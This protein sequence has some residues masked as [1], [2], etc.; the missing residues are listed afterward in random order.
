[1]CG[2]VVVSSHGGQA[3]PVHL[4]LAAIH[5]RGPD[6][7]GI[8][9]SP[10]RDCQLGHAR[11]SI[12]DLSPTGH[13]PMSDGSGRYMLCYNGETYNFPDLR[14]DLER[15][16]G[17]VTWRGSSDSEVIIEGFAREGIP[18]LDRLN[19]MF[20]L[21]IYDTQERL[22]HILRDPIGIKPLFIT[23]QQGG[24]YFC[25]EMK[26]LLALPGL[27]FD[28]RTAALAEQLSFM[29]VPEPYT[30]FEQIRK[31]EPGVC[32]SYRDG[33]LVASQPLFAHLA[34]A[35]RMH[36]EDE[37][38]QALRAAFDVAVRRQ[39]M[40]DVP[41]SVFLSGGLDSSAVALRAVQ[42]GA[43]VKDAYTIAFHQDDQRHD[44]QSDDLHH[45]RIMAERLGLELKVITAERNFLGLLP[46]LVRF[47]ED[48]FSDPAAINTYLISAGARRDGIKVL[49]SGQGADEYL[50]GYRRYLAEK[51]LAALPRPLRA[52]LGRMQG[53]LPATL[54]GRFNALN[55]RMRRL[56]Q[57]AA[58]TPQARLKAMYTWSPDATVRGLMHDDPGTAAD[59]AFNTYVA[60]HSHAD[61]L[62]TMMA[63]DRQYDLL[64]LN[65]CYTDRMSMAAS[66]EARVPF[67]DFDLVRTMNAIPMAM[68]VQG[69]QGKRVFKRAMTPALPQEI[70]NRAKA[71]FGLPIRAWL[72]QGSAL[73]DHYL[74]QARLQRQGLY[75]AAAVRQLLDAQFSG[76]ADHSHTLLT[77]L[78]QQLW[79]EQAQ[80]G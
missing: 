77:L 18:F 47:M 72:R 68:K 13:Q 60:Q 57:L 54:P 67:L 32:R 26:G 28:L 50:G 64:S 6:D 34:P 19:G 56:A 48:G 43:A 17:Q 22:L 59:V 24:V 8:Y 41:V 53:C 20:A 38:V 33:H 76:R 16:H 46:E 55:R 49:L 14:A 11:L 40:A 51:G 12:V 3:V 62:E 27:R 31:V 52:V 58:Q 21:A 63:V 44:A 2:I 37:A 74:D 10:A 29:Y 25:S 71:G 39:M 15:R 30:P 73:V 4:A 5:H 1:M 70:V 35:A 80:L 7:Q 79:L 9:V 61:V 65:L 45:A 42:A 75:N 69:R 78:C 36:D 66:V 23:E